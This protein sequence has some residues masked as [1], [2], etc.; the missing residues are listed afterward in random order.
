MRVTATII[1]GGQAGLAMSRCL[2]NRGVD[3]VVLERSEVANAWRYERWDSLRLLTPNWQSR[4]PGY[5][6][7]GDDPDGFR[8]MPELIRFLDQYARI[9]DAP[10]RTHTRV[11]AVEAIVSGYR[12]QTDDGEWRGRSVVLATG[13]CNIASVPGCAEGVP[14]SVDTLTSMEYRKPEQL[15][16]G[17][18]MA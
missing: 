9:I 14:S 18:V 8:T 16:P 4:L 7:Q 17:G 10:V 12:I 1:G 11:M 5:G 3:H 6:Y 13:A 2:V 15:A